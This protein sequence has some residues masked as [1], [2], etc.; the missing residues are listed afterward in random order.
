MSRWNESKT[1][2]VN[3]VASFNLMFNNAIFVLKRTVQW[4]TMASPNVATSCKRGIFSLLFVSVITVV[5]HV[6]MTKHAYVR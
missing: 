1:K 6:T 4:K 3:P 2:F 5:L